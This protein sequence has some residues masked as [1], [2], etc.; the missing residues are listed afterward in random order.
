MKPAAKRALWIAVGVLVLL[1]LLGLGLLPRLVA[2][3]M[4][5]LI[6]AP[7]EP[8]AEAVRLHETVAV[9]DLHSDAL[10]WDRDLLEHGDYGHVDLPRLL[11]GRVVLQGFTVVTKT[12]SGM[13]IE[14]N[15]AD[16]DRITLLAMAQA[17]PPRTWW[18]LRARALHQAAKLERFVAESDGRLV[19]IRTA[20]DLDALLA[21]RGGG[22]PAAGALLG[23]EGAHAL[24]GDLAG[25]DVLFDAGF[26]MIGFTHF[27]DNEVGGSAH[28]VQKGGLTE[29]GRVVLR[30]ME[31]LGIAADLAHASPALIDD[32]LELT[33]RPVLVSH[34]GVKG[35]CDNARNLDDDR[36]R[37]I[38]ATGGVVGIGLWETAIC[39]DG[40]E[41]WAAAVRHAVDVAGVDH[42]GLGSDWDGAVAAI[43]DAAGTA[44]LTAALMRAGFADDEVRRIMGGNV[45]RVLGE[46]L[47]DAGPTP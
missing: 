18:S 36:L 12:P 19:L 24:E 38:A 29:L 28:G 16:S 21:R 22:Q 46:L 1:V 11:A 5:P 9:V 17:W 43:V 40:P 23:L 44:H 31:Q 13:N 20:A 6:G 37:R 41:R 2:S 26:R 39:G 35:T 42:V 30:R 27:F 32:V 14:A 3:S 45:I 47:P 7:G 8:S 25:V 15:S 4:N 34:T 33:T 10:L